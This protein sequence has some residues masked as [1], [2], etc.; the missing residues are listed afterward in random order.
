MEYTVVIW[1]V[2][3][4]GQLSSLNTGSPF[5]ETLVFAPEIIQKL[6]ES[7]LDVQ[8]ARETLHCHGLSDGIFTLL[9]GLS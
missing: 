9:K 3:G 6:V 4:K 2:D 8:D 1:E 7:V 5:T